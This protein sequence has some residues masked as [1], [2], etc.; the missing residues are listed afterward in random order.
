M[1]KEENTKKGMIAGGIEEKIPKTESLK[2]ENKILG[3]IFISIGV[4]IGVLLII[5]LIARASTHFKYKD[6]KFDMIKEGDLIFYHTSFP[7][8]YNKNSSM[9]GAATLGSYN[10]YIRNDPRE[11]EEKVPAKGTLASIDDTVINMTQEFDCNGDQVIAIANLVNLYNAI[12]KKIMRDENASCD[13]FGRYM[14]I[15]I[16]LG[17]ETSIELFGPNCYNINIK[18][19]EILEGTERFIVGMLVKIHVEQSQ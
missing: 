11:L 9:S 3:N 13:P 18:D 17:N 8:M 12:G 16:Q 14:Y 7:V 1:I 6:V 19:C 10:I 2:K 15:N 4:F 5:V